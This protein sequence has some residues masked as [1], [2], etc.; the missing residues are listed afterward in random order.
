[1][2]VDQV[3]PKYCPRCGDFFGDTVCTNCA[4]ISTKES[5]LVKTGKMFAV[6]VIVLHML[7]FLLCLAFSPNP[8]NYL[9]VL[10]FD[11]IVWLGPINEFFILR[12]SPTTIL[13][14][15][16]IYSILIIMGIG[17]S[18][19]GVKY[20]SGFVL[21]IIGAVSWIAHGFESLVSAFL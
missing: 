18:C 14:M 2:I 20:Q 13:G 4:G 6:L 17:I 15:S 1:M 19:M 9:N 5:P 16:G 8:T 10:Y 11:S 7:T 3:D 21:T 12:M